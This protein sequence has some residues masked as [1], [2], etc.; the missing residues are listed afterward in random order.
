MTLEVTQR[1]R[2]APLPARAARELWEGRAA[3]RCEAPSTDRGWA[4]SASHRSSG[5]NAGPAQSPSTS[6]NS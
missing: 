5:G 2:P 6:G 3:R 4:S 1:S